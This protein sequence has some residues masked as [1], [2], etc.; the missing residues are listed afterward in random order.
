MNERQNALTPRQEQVDC[1]EAESHQSVVMIP[2]GRSDLLPMKM[3]LSGMAAHYNAQRLSVSAPCE[4]ME[5][6]HADEG[7]KGEETSTKVSIVS[8]RT[9][10]LVYLVSKPVSIV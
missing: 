8:V 4:V 5:S 6:T 9:A 10:A 2:A 1:S 7:S 3:K